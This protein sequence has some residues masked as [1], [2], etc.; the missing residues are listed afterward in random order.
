MGN[1]LIA[2]SL[3]AFSLQPEGGLPLLDAWV[4]ET[5]LIALIFASTFFGG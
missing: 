2:F 1:G 5:I 3:T 4:F